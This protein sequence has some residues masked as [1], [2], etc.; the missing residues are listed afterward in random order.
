M[1]TVVLLDTSLSMAR[2]ICG[3]AADEVQR[4]H[5]AAHGLGILFEHL[6]S[7]YR[8]EFTALAAFSSACKLLVPFTRDCNVLQEEL[9]CVDD[10]DKTCIEVALQTASTLVQEEWGLNTCCQI[11]LVT[12]GC[13]GIGKG[14]L[15]HSLRTLAQRT[16]NST[17]PLPFAFPAKLHV[18]CAASLEE[19]QAMGTLDSLERL[20][21]L[22][23]G[24]GKVYTLEGSIS[25]K[26]A[27]AMFCKLIDDAFSPFLSVLHCGHLSSEVHL[28]PRPEPIVPENQ[29]EPHPIT[30]SAD[31]QIV[32]FIE[33]G[34][35][36]SPPVLSRHLV[37]PTSS[38]KDG[39][40]E[41]G[42]PHVEDGGEE[43]VSVQKAGSRPSFCVLLHGS[44]K[45]EAMVAM[46]Q[47]GPEWLGMLHSQ[48]DSKKKS[49]LMLSL[50][51]PGTEMMPWLGRLDRLTPIS[52]FA[53][54]PYGEDNSKMPFP[55]I[56]E[57][58][59]SYAQNVV[60]WIKPS[61]LQGDIQRVLRNARKLP[62]KLQTFYKEV[63][64]LRRAALACGFT[65]LPNAVAE[66]LERECSL[67]PDKT[68]P[69]V[70]FQLIHAAKQ[71]RRS[72]RRPAEHTNYEYTIVPL[73]THFSD[74]TGD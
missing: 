61:A 72:T 34:D 49:N 51:Y 25:I 43:E 59:R 40:D 6:S 22:N 57:S 63:N 50:F 15:R 2:P 69:D 74:N 13:L 27:Q 45:V 29:L 44:L 14:S 56:P 70:A 66:L 18:M 3:E 31:L 11:V 55:V 19:L 37:L 64:R 67:L 12:D 24:Q 33:I 46:V 71:L 52:D 58:K 54:N 23:N 48:A 42:A 30:V 9:S 47:L 53:E 36:A 8:L 28:F 26:A 21:E 1:P 60:V 38:T 7:Q 35:V 62:E 73:R 41:G 20:V 4:K 5:L 16:E 65:D 39:G 32:G 68:H 17:F 10:Q